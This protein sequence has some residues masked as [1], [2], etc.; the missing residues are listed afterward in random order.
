MGTMTKTPELEALWH[1]SSARLRAWFERETG[2]A[3]AAEDLVQET[4]VRVHERLDTLVDAD[5]VRAWVGK[6]ARNVLIDH[7]RRRM[8]SGSDESAAV[9]TAAAPEEETTLDATVAGWLEDF[10][11]ELEPSDAAA[12]RRVD[13]EGRTQAELAAAEGLSLAG[14]KSRVQRARARLR[15]RLEACC[16]FAFDARGGIVDYARRAPTACD[17]DGCAE[18]C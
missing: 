6:I 5:S 14:A 7:R 13:L 3:S 18:D 1:E 9:E 16:S 10:L 2:D 8:A 15:A 11:R 12:L 17:P 4:F